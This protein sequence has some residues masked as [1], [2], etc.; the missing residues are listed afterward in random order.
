MP[1]PA[2]SSS[3]A[4]YCLSCVH[5]QCSQAIYTCCG[6][7]IPLLHGNGQAHSSHPP[8]ARKVHGCTQHLPP[9]SS[10]R[11]LQHTIEAIPHKRNGDDWYQA[12]HEQRH[13]T[14]VG[15]AA[16]EP[17]AQQPKQKRYGALRGRSASQLSAA[18]WS[19]VVRACRQVQASKMMLP[20]V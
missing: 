3:L 19:A 14:A 5:Q 9:S 1:R 8:V 10:Q 20:R 2:P 16:Y 18:W 13:V 15:E 12:V 17:L 11:G 6:T 7:M 4:A